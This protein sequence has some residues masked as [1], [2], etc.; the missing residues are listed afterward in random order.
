MLKF[1]EKK[2]KFANNIIFSK[3]TFY[4]NWLLIK[5]IQT[6][7]KVSKSFQ[8]N[9]FLLAHIRFFIKFIYNK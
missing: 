1:N 4:K 3:N 5:N 8:R 2:K 7:F 6:T 9:I